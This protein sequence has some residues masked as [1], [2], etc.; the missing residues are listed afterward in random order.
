M[1]Y[2]IEYNIVG[3]Q[4]DISE[5]L[6]YT[7]DETDVE[8]LVYKWQKAMGKGWYVKSEMCIVYW[9]DRIRPEKLYDETERDEI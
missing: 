1:R 4:G 6:E 8:Y 7:A 2:E 9:D 3:Y 5:V